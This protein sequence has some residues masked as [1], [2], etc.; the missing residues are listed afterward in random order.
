MTITEVN[1]RAELRSRAAPLR[2]R[3]QEGADEGIVQLVASTYGIPYEVG[4]GWQEQIEAGAFSSATSTVIPIWL[5]HKYDANSLLGY[6]IKIEDTPT[7]LV[8]TV[9]MF[10]DD[11]VVAKV[12]QAMKAGALDEWSVG[13]YA[14][15]IQWDSK[16]PDLDIIT[17]GDLVEV[18]VCM[19]GANP[20]TGTI[21]M[22]DKFSTRGAVDSHTH[23]HTHAD[24]TT[25]SHDH[26]HTAS[27]DHGAG[28][29]DAPHT[30]GHI[31]DVDGDGDDDEA[32]PAPD[33]EVTR[34]KMIDLMRRASFRKLLGS[35]NE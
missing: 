23:E 4:Y 25:H 11:P 31:G 18:S 22:R 15:Q 35:S 28:D 14:N 5:Q 9:Q 16:N 10:L 27:Y 13:F 1:P 19:R 30:H 8:L 32:P 33:D 20:Q 34:D 21:S 29:S 17:E 7:E 6:S 2:V 12:W 3:I 24:G 26:A